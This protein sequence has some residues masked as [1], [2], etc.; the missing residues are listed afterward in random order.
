MADRE[1]NRALDSAIRA[2]RDA[3]RAE[4]QTLAGKADMSRTRGDL[5]GL[6]HRE[7]DRRGR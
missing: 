6:Y 7:M 5:Y 1:T 3:K 2:D 4:R